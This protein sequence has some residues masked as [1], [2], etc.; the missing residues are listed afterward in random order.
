MNARGDGVHGI[1]ARF[2]DFAEIFRRVRA[3]DVATGEIHDGFRAVQIL[4]PLADVFAVPFDFLDAVVS[5]SRSER[6][7]TTTS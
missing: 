4:Y 1:H 6:V 7:S 5:R 3:I 2:G